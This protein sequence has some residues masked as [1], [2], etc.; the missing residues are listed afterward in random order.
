MTDIYSHEKRSKIMARVSATGTSPELLVRQVTHGMGYRFRLHGENFPGRPDLVFPR[1][2][3]VIFVHGCF[4]HGHENCKKAK[5]PE[6]NR[7]FWEKKL[8]RNME[9]DDKNAIMLKKM[10]WMVLVVW[11]CETR[12]REQLTERIRCFLDERSAVGRQ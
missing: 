11:E 2:N 5:R 9:R 8:S 12:N 1:H 4:W 3:K 7:A 10:G 6:T